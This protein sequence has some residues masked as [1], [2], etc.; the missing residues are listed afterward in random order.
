MNNKLHLAL[1]R[2]V[3]FVILGRFFNEMISKIDMKKRVLGFVAVGLVAVVGVTS[4]LQKP[5]KQYVPNPELKE[6][7]EAKGAWNYLNNMRANQVTGVIDPADVAAA[8]QAVQGMAAYKTSS[9]NLTWEFVGPDNLGGRTRDFLIDRNNSSTLYASGVAGGVYKSTTA[10]LS[11]VKVSADLDNVAVVSMAQAANGDLF[12][13]TGE[14]AFAPT[15]GEGTATS[16]GMTGGGIYKSTDGGQSWTQLSATVPPANVTNNAW[17]SIGAMGADPTNA[18][19]I[20]AGT[21]GGL[22]RSDDGGVTWSNPIPP[23]IASGQCRD[24]VVAN[25][26]SIWASVGDRTV[27]SPNGDDN[28][29]VEKSKLIVS[30]TDLPRNSPRTLFAVSPQNQDIVYCLQ[31][32]GSGMRALYRSTDRGTTWTVIGQPTTLWDPLC[33]FSGSANGCIGDWARLL[34]VNPQN[35]NHIFVGGLRLWEWK[36]NTGWRRVD[37]FGPFYVHADKHRMKFDP[38]NA[39]IVYVL[40]DGGI[41]KSSDNGFTWGVFNKNYRTGQF[42]HIGIGQDRTVVGGTQDNGSWKIDGTGNTPQEGVTVG[43]IAYQGGGFHAGDGGYSLVSWLD[44]DVFFTSYQLGTIG[45]SENKGE[46]YSSFWDPRQLTNCQPWYGRNCNFSSWMVPYELY[47]TENDALSQ[48]SIWFTANTAISSLGFGGGDTSFTNTLKRPQDAAQFIASTFKVESGALLITSDAQ[49]NLSGDGKGT[50]DAATGNYTVTFSSTPFAEIIVTCDVQYT[51]GSTIKVRSKTNGLPFNHLLTT[52]LS[53]GDSLQIQDPVQS[54]FIAGLNGNVWMTRGALDFSML[55]RWY[56]IAKITGVAQCVAISDNGQYAWVGTENGRLYRISNLH[57]ARTLETGDVDED[58]STVLVKYDQVASFSSRNVTSVSVDPNNPDR[59]IV[60]VGNYGNSTY[61][62]YSDNATSSSPTFTS[63]QGN[64]PAFPVYSS[65]FDKGNPGTVVIGTEYGI[66]ATDNIDASSVTWTNENNGFT[67]SPVFRLVQYRTNKSS[68]P[69]QTILEGDIYLGSHGSSIWKT[70]TLQTTRPI[71]VEEEAEFDFEEK[72]IGLNV[73]PNPATDFT[74][75]ELNL[76]KAEDVT[77]LVRDLNGRLID[78]L[79]FNRLAAGK[80]EIRINT[81]E[82][83]AG[84]YFL[85]VRIGTEMK[86]A[87]FIVTR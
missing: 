75:L 63:V 60:T 69:D 52:S 12:A 21:G 20:Y 82:L 84:T 73:F 47:E 9:L 31:S 17:S 59:I 64:L 87:K 11:W 30:S 7:F 36:L 15:T 68:T 62:Y 57:L 22:R 86:S 66:F 4:Y 71:S 35:S 39:N 19:R 29:W 3:N 54:M 61:V 5:Q 13:G 6:A 32:A 10:G 41:G 79:K 42:Y 44:E 78:Q 51:S 83:S 45:R 46:S 48:D 1:K 58:T 34:Q 50:F 76:R 25:D 67:P 38:N 14:N 26:G 27:Y 55:P 40:T 72:E 65:V 70:N 85:S 77:V 8:R 18:N 23:T 49:G 16:P 2:F 43:G 33:D 56:K 80:R 74:N 24:L 28:S 37:G 81:S 53:P